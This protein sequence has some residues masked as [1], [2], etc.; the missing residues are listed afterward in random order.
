VVSFVVPS[1]ILKQGS[2]S[3]AAHSS[4]GDLRSKPSLQFRRFFA[5]ETPPDGHSN[6]KRGD[7]LFT[8]AASLIDTESAM[9]EAYLAPLLDVLRTSVRQNWTVLGEQVTS[10]DLSRAANAN[11]EVWP[12]ISVS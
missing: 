3:A 8:S 10:L 12:F 7:E 11:P 1:D 9:S 5:I 6:N 4:P 2:A